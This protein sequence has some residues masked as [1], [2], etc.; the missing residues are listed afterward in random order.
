M[1]KIVLQGFMSLFLVACVENSLE[2]KDHNPVKELHYNE[3]TGEVL[4]ERNFTYDAN[5]NLISDH[6]RGLK[7]GM[8]E[9]VITYTY[10]QQDRLIKLVN[11][12]VGDVQDS[13]AIVKYNY[14]G[15]RRV[16]DEYYVDEVES[17]LVRK[18]VYHYSFHP[19][20]DSIENFNHRKNGE[21]IADGAIYYT[22]DAADR[23]LQEARKFFTGT[24]V[25]IKLNTYG[26]GLLAQSCS[27]PNIHD[28]KVYCQRM[29][30]NDDGKITKLYRT[31]TGTPD[32]LEEEYLYDDARLIE[33]RTFNQVYP[34]PLYS[35]NVTL[36]TLSVKL[37]Y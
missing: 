17:F 13:Y 32:V 23:V 35:S 21:F 37:E 34:S 3:D 30:Y 19:G 36:Y 1:K 16:S 8:Q 25:V 6:F 28:G 7:E 14:E 18:E 2:F 27:P 15:T 11:R 5:G 24:T 20:P 29:E 4:A 10:D 22:Y 26:G 12:F 33:K 9:N 31:E